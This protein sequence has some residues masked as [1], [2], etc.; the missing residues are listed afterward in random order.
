MISQFDL[1]S[2]VAL[3]VAVLSLAGALLTLIGSIGLVRLRTFYERLHPPTMGSTMGIG[4][5]LVASMLLFSTLRERAVLHEIL[6]GLFVTLTT[7]VTFMLLIRASRHRDAATTAD[8][9]E[10]DDDDPSEIGRGRPQ[11]RHG[12]GAP[13]PE[14]VVRTQGVPADPPDRPVL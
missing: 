1:P 14:D 2:W 8:R 4:L 11:T 9:P 10:D 12:Q 7:P 13:D 3:L 6:I 5:V